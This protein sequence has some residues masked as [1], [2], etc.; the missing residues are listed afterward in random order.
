ME[1]FWD[2]IVA[3]LTIAASNVT[4]AVYWTGDSCQGFLCSPPGERYHASPAISPNVVPATLANPTKETAYL[5]S[6]IYFP[7]NT[8]FAAFTQLPRQDEDDEILVLSSQGY[9]AFIR[10]SRLEFPQ[11]SVEIARIKLSV[12]EAKQI[13]SARDQ[14]GY[15]QSKIRACAAAREITLGGK[16]SIGANSDLGLAEA[17][18]S[19]ELSASEKRIFDA[20]RNVVID[21][22]YDAARGQLVEIQ[23]YEP[24][25][26]VTPTAAGF[27]YDVFVNGR[28]RTLRPE[29]ANIIGL[30]VENGRPVIGCLEQY[31]S[32]AQ[33]LSNEHDLD[34]KW[35]PIVAAMTARW[36]KYQSLD[37]CERL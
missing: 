15:Y 23:A 33:F 8:E 35:I 3:F 24:C 10:K 14:L 9:W 29:E 16:F 37:T 34:E 27:R 7:A 31:D 5:G 30:P 6:G 18:V 17:E 25:G 20:G 21:R 2:T 12:N 13:V 32:F 26:T 22:F 36:R 19:V 4:G 28:A 11:D 1:E